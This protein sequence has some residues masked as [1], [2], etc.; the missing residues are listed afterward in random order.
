MV[1]EGSTTLVLLSGGQEERTPLNGGQ[2]VVV[3]QNTWHRFES[4]EPVKVMTVTPQPTD[5]SA[6]RPE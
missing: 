1:A 5:H 4:P 2:L 3:P 6:V